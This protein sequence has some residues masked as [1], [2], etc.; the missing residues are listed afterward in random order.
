MDTSWLLFAAI[1]V[2]CM[3]AGFLCLETGKVRSKNSINVAA[4]NLSDFIVSSILFWMF[5]FA[6][7]FGQT[8]M[9]V[10]GTSEFLF[11]ATHT[12]W[13]Y[14]FFLFQMMFCGTAATLVSGAVAERM[15]YRGYLLITVVLCTLIYPF[16]GHWAWSSL[17]DVNNQG[18]L[19]GLGFID[20]AGSTVVH[21][22]GGWISLAAIIVLGA[23][24]GRFDDNQTFPAG[25][26]L[27]L[28]VLGTLLIWLGW[29]G[30]NGGSTLTLNAQVPV[31]L[32]NT[33]LA[34]AF[35][36][37][38]ASALFI[39]RHR[40]LDVTIMLNG[41]I[42]G[43]VAITAS[44]NVV[45]PA[46]AALIGI[47]AGLLMYGGE[48]LLL[49][50]RLDDALGVVPAH[51]FAGIWGTLGVAFFHQ[52]ISLF[53]NAFWSQF[54]SQLIGIVVVGVFSFTLAWFSLRFI[55]RFIPLRV[56]AEQEYL[57]M[58]VTEHN[59]STELLDLLNS[60]H[61]QERQANFNQPVPEEP[62]TEVGQIA[63]QYNRV[64]ERVQ[65]EMS[66][67]DGL[68]KDFKSSEKRKSAI[69][70]SSM[71]SIVTINLDGNIIEFNPAAERTFGCLQ[72]KV[73]NRNFIEL[74]I[75]ES[76]RPAVNDSLKNKFVTSSGLLIN[77]RNTLTLRRSTN[78]NFPAEITIT[79]TTFGSSISN[80]F[81]LHIRDVT[82]QRRLQ[83]KLQELA[84]S[85][86]LTGLYN[87]TFFLDALQVALRN[88]H[89]DSKSVAVFFLDLDRF[90]KINDTLG[91]KTGDELLTEVAARLIN[92]TRERDTICRW[93]G[94]EFVIMMTGNHDETTVVTSATKIL[95]VMR[96]AVNLGGR[97][98][99][100][101][102]SIGI[103]ITNDATCQPTLLIQQA[104]I[105]MY[106]AKQAGR[107]NFKIFELNMARDA[108]DQFNFEQTLRRA[109]QKAQQFVMLYQPKVDKNRN[110]VGLE[111]LVRLELSPGKYTSP[112]QFIPVAEGSGQIIALEELILRLVL[113]QLAIWHKSY[114]LTPRVSINLSGVHLL[115]DT[116][117]P[118]LNQCIEEFNIPGH[119]IEFEVTES[120]FLNDIDRCIQVLKVLQ[121]LNIAI[122]IDDF[123][124]GY[125]S[126]NYLKNLP[127][128]VLKI[129]R[130]FVLE[131]ASQKED[132]KI[133]STIIELASTLGLNTVAEGVENMEQFDFLV[134][135]G[136]NSF[137]G[138]Y[139]YRPLSA[140]RINGLLADTL[141]TTTL[142]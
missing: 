89:Q 68:L 32:V 126:L 116:F 69:L 83:E 25:S 101:P 10:F 122:S 118:F 24:A 53:S 140:D 95:Q 75:L 27:P 57:G 47:I 48:R 115:S 104:D 131:C 50:W 79:G 123:G 125:S 30:F 97:D 15:S 73:I 4:K 109:I 38:S 61:I 35:G 133:C 37:L 70:N 39:S 119:W 45:Q 49:H 72:A 23:R 46:S 6:I 74:F 77:R 29:F 19:E 64:I 114:P 76:D 7:M 58:N 59:A 112:T 141:E 52:S 108:S 138:Y 102:T 8:N 55:N 5:G 60:M 33:C 110:I 3:Q 82:R 103:S 132:A 42:A 91:H 67:R 51:L 94:D 43:L 34:A 128:D 28:S 85:D 121:G 21:S 18:W 1:L 20:F 124:T 56:S 105:A 93:G 17:Y 12:P 84:Y 111:A 117:L 13:Q 71:D 120:V 130:A 66:Q 40:F 136:C 99:K 80:E 92:V 98:L 134:T 87:R 9:G 107:D 113:S 88:I 135:H 100:I 2:F 11:G 81:T 129:D 22:V 78:D 106:C 41:V 54:L 31:I 96:E 14:S 26:N 65:Y 36:G 86:P 63:R 127:V 90:K 137:Q 62:F 142:N 16:V 139:F 44:A